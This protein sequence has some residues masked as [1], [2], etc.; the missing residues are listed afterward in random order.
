MGGK[1]E[2]V[3]VP[4]NRKSEI[5]ERVQERVVC[6][7]NAGLPNLISPVDVDDPENLYYIN[8]VSSKCIITYREMRLFLSSASCCWKDVFSIPNRLL[9]DSKS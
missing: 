9:I 6:N 5:P 4:K 2:I 8:I 3:E 7:R 1:E